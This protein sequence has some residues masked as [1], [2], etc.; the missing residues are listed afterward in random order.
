MNPL[1]IDDIRQAAIRLAGKIVTTPLLTSPQLDALTGTTTLVKAENLQRT[2]SFKIRGALNKIMSLDEQERRRGIV[3]FSSGN[4]GQAVAAAAR[5]VGCPAVIVLPSTAPRIK[6]DNCHW[7]G[8]DVVTYDPQTEDRE[9]VGMTFV[10]DR[11]MTLVHPF[12]DPVVMAGQ[13]TAGLEIVD[14]ARAQ[15]HRI[16]AVVVNCSGG[17]LAS[18]VI[19]AIS[20]RYPR[21]RLFLTEPEGGE[22]MARSLAS[23]KPERNP[24]GTTTLLDA[25]SGPNAGAAPL[26]VLK[27]RPVTCLSIRD[28]DALHA[29][30]V[31]F[32]L[33]KIVVEPGGAAS[34]A[35]VLKHPEHFRDKTVAIVCSGGNVDPAVFGRA[36]AAR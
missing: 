30:E 9:T 18:G 27:T 3:A 20:D 12:D 24:P 11:G 34:L 13:G 14:Q 7:W 19:T 25:L 31:A 33:L 15:G 17:G 1:T 22:K 21:A 26:S 29:M 36:L 5:Q 10:H 16:D 32:R 2:G 23:G 8:A 35:A 28:A 6:V 4:H